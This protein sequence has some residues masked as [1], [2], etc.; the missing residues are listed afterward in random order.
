M[1][2][3]LTACRNILVDQENVDA[4]PHAFT[5]RIGAYIRSGGNGKRKQ[6]STRRMLR[7]EIHRIV[8]RLSHVAI[9]PAP[10]SPLAAVS[11]DGIIGAPASGAIAEI[12]I[13]LGETNLRQ[14]E[15][16]IQP[17]DSRGKGIAHSRDAN[18]GGGIGF[19][20]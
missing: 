10:A 6:M 13:S 2:T 19:G 7:K 16:V 9:L 20:H 11:I 4:A 17:P 18:A 3:H 15:H 14:M 5:D 12:K 8:E 1:D